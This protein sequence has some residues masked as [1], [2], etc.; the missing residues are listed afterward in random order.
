[1]KRPVSYALIVAIVAAVTI[2]AWIGRSSVQ[3]PG[4]LP[5]PDSAASATA[6]DGAAPDATDISTGRAEPGRDGAADAAAAEAGAAPD[7]VATQAETGI[8]RIPVSPEFAS[9][10][11]AGGGL[12]EFH[13][14]L[15][16]EIRDPQWASRIE[17]FLR[18]YFSSTLDP[19]NIRI[20]V[21]ECRATACEILAVGYGA[22]ALVVW[23]QGVSDFIDSFESDEAFEAFFGGPGNMGCGGSDSSPGVIT[24]NCTFQRVAADQV[25]DAPA[26][27]FSLDTPYPDGVTVEPIAV[28]DAVATLIESSRELYDLHRRLERQTRDFGWANYIEPLVAE[29]I[30]SLSP[31][32]GVEFLG[33]TCRETLCEVQMTAANDEFFID[34]LPVMFQFH[35]LEWHDLTT[36]GMDGGDTTGFDGGEL[37]DGESSRL[38][39]FLERR[40]ATQP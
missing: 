23:M 35:Q 25:E 2:V 14:T 26:E 39:W 31:E 11:E 8:V 30:E 32:V 3:E 20:D 6:S 37:V 21:I 5:K 1:L 24:L 16:A 22:E 28:D 13:K 36:A 33:V 38:V 10:F 12:A 4:A 19:S 9:Q 7:G 29:Y 40:A 18:D 27:T 15:E 34:W 17:N